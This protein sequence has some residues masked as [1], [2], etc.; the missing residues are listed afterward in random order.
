MTT[1]VQTASQPQH[2]QQKVDRSTG[3][4]YNP[5]A[6]AS[7][8]RTVAALVSKQID[9]ELS[10]ELGAAIPAYTQRV[11]YTGWLS[12]DQIVKEL[13]ECLLAWEVMAIHRHD[14]NNLAEEF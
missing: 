6:P 4:I 14:L 13:G 7:Q 9:E 5:A 12:Y 1:L 8:Y 3:A 10:Q 11:S 2:P